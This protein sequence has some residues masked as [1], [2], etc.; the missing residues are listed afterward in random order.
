MR[1][2]IDCDFFDGDSCRRK[3]PSSYQ[4]P[5]LSM[6]DGLKEY[7]KDPDNQSGWPEVS[8]EDWCGEFTPYIQENHE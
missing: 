5:Y 6:V 1:K 4:Y 2:C 7:T 3:A 8:T